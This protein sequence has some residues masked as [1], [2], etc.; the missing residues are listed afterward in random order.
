MQ[1]KKTHIFSDHFKQCEKSI[2]ALL[3]TLSPKETDIEKTEELLKFLNDT[4]NGSE[5]VLG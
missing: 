5:A 3:P 4:I 2:R 1:V